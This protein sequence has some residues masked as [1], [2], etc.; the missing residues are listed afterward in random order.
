ML[1]I[2]TG[3]EPANFPGMLDFEIE[4]TADDATQD[5]L[6][7]MTR[8]LLGE[9]RRTDV[10]SAELISAGEAPEGSKGDPITIGALAMT[11]LPAVLPSVIDL[12]KDWSARKA[13][14]IVKFKGQ[15]IE[16]EGSA[17]ELEKLLAKLSKG[18]K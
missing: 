4:I 6:D 14:R 5:E 9:L 13:G 16:F 12:I 11:V 18:K 8:S 17:E 2:N 3:G 15:G 10:E 1:E 7:H